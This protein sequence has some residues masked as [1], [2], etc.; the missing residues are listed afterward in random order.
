MQPNSYA[1]CPKCGANDAKAVSFTWWGGVVGPKILHHVKCQACSTAYNGKTGNANT[2][3]IVI[4]F[5][6]VGLLAF[7]IMAVAVIAFKMI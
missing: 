2:A 3:G 4:Y 7:V 6:V 5:I 1:P